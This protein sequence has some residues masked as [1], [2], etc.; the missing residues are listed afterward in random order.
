[1]LKHILLLVTGTGLAS[2]LPI[3]A[4]PLLTRLYTP[5][6]FGLGELYLISTVI[7]ALFVT[8]RLDAAIVIP[9]ESKELRR[10]LSA[11]FTNSIFISI[12]T[13]LA[14]VPLCLFFG[15]DW[16]F[17]LLPLSIFVV[18][19][20][21]TCVFFNIRNR[22]YK[23]I[24]VY[25]VTYI[26]SIVLLKLIF[27]YLGFSV[28]GII[29]GTLLGQVIGLVFIYFRNLKH[30]DFSFSFNVAD[31]KQVVL[32]DYQDFP[33]HSLPQTLI[34][35]GREYA[36]SFI[37]LSLFN[38]AVLGIYALTLKILKSPMYLVGHA[39][40]DVV[41]ERF[42]KAQ[43]KKEHK[44]I[45]RFLFFSLTLIALPYFVL[46]YF[47]S[48]ITSFVFG[49]EWDKAGEFAWIL[50]PWFYFSF[51]SITFER[52]AMI[53]REQKKVFRVNLVGD[54]LTI[55]AFACFGYFYRDINASLQAVSLMGS[56]ARIVMVVVVIKMLKANYQT[57][58]KL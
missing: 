42:S 8:L 26:G 7:L 28:A 19:L 31:W 11:I 2:L 4:T 48:D 40:S 52:L 16:L 22:S 27:G 30:P 36:L 47:I 9:K 17:S 6:E 13:F 18:G 15:L 20:F 56:M 24:G 12:L 51:I 57:E 55:A 1:M 38:P 35:S 5:E 58:S 23:S 10:L 44:D 34:N 32:K 21:E 25:K 33:R 43:G 29:L 3:F 14:I 46:F 37:I 45:F 39:F 54:S 50:S 41:Y 49:K 53:I